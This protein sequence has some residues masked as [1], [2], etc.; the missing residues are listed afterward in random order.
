LGKPNITWIKILDG[1]IFMLVGSPC[2]NDD[3]GQVW[4]L[5]GWLNPQMCW[6]YHQFWWLNPH[7]CVVWIPKPHFSASSGSSCSGPWSCCSSWCSIA[8]LY[9]PFYSTHQKRSCFDDVWLCVCSE[10]GWHLGYSPTWPF[11]HGAM[12]M[13]I[14]GAIWGKWWGTRFSDKAMTT[15]LRIVSMFFLKKTSCGKIWMVWTTCR[16]VLFGLTGANVLF[17]HITQQEIWYN[18]QHQY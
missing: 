4:W 11:F 6:L 8:W 2:L 3:I 12:E 17:F 7:F 5:N 9:F 18:L 15:H 14:H 10:N 1:W 16:H 13:I